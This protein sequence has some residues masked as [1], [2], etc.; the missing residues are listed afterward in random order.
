MT[1]LNDMSVI[2]D[3]P[4]EYVTRNGGRATVF[5]VKQGGNP[6]TTRFDAKGDVWRKVRGKFRPVDYTIWHVS[7]RKYVLNESKDDIV[8]RYLEEKEAA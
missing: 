7:G 3:G 4:G 5:E 2:V 8:G 1:A 6:E